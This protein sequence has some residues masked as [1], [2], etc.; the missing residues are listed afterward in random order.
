MCKSNSSC[1][2]GN[3]SGGFSNK[4]IPKFSLAKLFSSA[5]CKSLITDSKY[6]VLLLTPYGSCEYAFKS[7][8]LSAIPLTTMSINL[9]KIGTGFQ[10]R[11]K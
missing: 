4:L 2:S 11:F 5:V 3:L 9:D 7:K 8:V 1:E 6:F 10:S